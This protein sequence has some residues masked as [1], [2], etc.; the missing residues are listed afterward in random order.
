[1]LIAISVNKKEVS[2]LGE[3]EKYYIYEVHDK[4]IIRK[5]EV[6]K[7]KQKPITNFLNEK[8][9]NVLITGK[10]DPVLDEGLKKTGIKIVTDIVG[11]PEKIIN[12]YL[13]QR[14]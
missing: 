13:Y 4:Y 14:L 2:N 3:C 8:K 6:K 11:D 7:P 10:M 9:V 12:D 1:M 5:K